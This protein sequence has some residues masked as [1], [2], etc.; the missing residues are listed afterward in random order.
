M[1]LF[2]I[3]MIKIILN[4]PHMLDFEN[5]RALFRAEMKRLKRK[6][7]NDRVIYMSLDRKEVFQQSF[8][9]IMDKKP[10]DLKNRVKID[11]EGE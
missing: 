2:D 4:S 5:K 7:G 10:Q 8:N 9:I 3:P 1:S 11:F 6:F